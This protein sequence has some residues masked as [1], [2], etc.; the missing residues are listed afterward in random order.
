M[1]KHL[2]HDGADEKQKT[3]S[4]LIGDSELSNNSFSIFS[5]EG[6]GS[7]IFLS[8]SSSAC[9]LLMQLFHIFN[10]FL[11]SLWQITIY[12]IVI[13]IAMSAIDTDCSDKLRIDLFFRGNIRVYIS[14]SQPLFV[15]FIN[16]SNGIMIRNSICT[17]QQ[18]LDSILT[19]YY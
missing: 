5:I 11:R 10:S 7:N 9:F 16:W 14:K 15:C 17:S 3:S 6:D 4:P 13:N 19:F 12:I 2:P 1:R 18:K 8:S